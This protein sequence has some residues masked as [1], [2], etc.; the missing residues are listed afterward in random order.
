MEDE[1]PIEEEAAAT[2]SATKTGRHLASLSNVTLAGQTMGTPTYM[3]PEQAR[4]ATKVDNR[5]DIYSLGCTLYVLV[6]GQPGFH[7]TT[8]L[9]VMTKHASDPV[10]RP[11][12]VNKEVPRGLA[13][14]IVKMLAKKPADRY[15]SAD[16]LI[17]ALE[18]FLGLQGANKS[19]Q[20][21]QHLRT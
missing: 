19:V 2:R 21:E 20:S 14:I 3:A 13:D 12:L 8:P 7:G 11:D 16:D 10:A 6:T 15:Q 1:K 4:D 5:A 17:K 18:S 9:E